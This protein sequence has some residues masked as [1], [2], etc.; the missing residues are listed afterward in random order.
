MNTLMF[1][2][3]DKRIELVEYITGKMKTILNY[4]T[5]IEN[6]KRISKKN[7]IFSVEMLIAMIWNLIR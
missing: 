5:K 2:F 3:D 6:I 4:S 7:I 1:I